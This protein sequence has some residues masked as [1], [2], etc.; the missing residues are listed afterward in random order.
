MITKKENLIKGL[1]T[2]IFALENDTIFYNWTTQSS[3]NCG[4]VAQAILHL[5]ADD[6]G[7]LF[8]PLHIKFR[9]LT[10]NKEKSIEHS[11][12]NS[13]KYLC[14]ITGKSGID[15]L[16]RLFDAGMSREDVIHLEYLENAVI[17]KRAGI[18]TTKI[19]PEK[20][21]TGEN[22]IMTSVPVV[23]KRK[24]IAGFLGYTETVIE[25]TEQLT[26]IFE[27][28][29]VE[30]PDKKYHTKK[31]NLILYLKAWVSILEEDVN[32]SATLSKEQV[33]EELLKAVAGEDYERAASLRDRLVSI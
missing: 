3:C 21:K 33:Q 14:P 24:G 4:V 32:K 25:P 13:I 19:E 18:R 23:K 31:S 27:T 8:D 17:L 5:P 20:I 7:I 9:A 22:K 30:V 29:M 10:G 1:K 15:I 16:D 12:K 6:I 26:E 28:R 2:A 11:W